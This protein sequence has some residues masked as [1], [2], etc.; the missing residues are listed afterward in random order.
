MRIT[1]FVSICLMF[2]SFTSAQNILNVESPVQKVKDSSTLKKALRDSKLNVHFR[3]NHIETYNKDSL[4]DYYA[5]ALTSTIKFE[6][7][8]Y[9]GFSLGTGGQYTVDIGS[10]DLNTP[11]KS[12]G[13]VSRYEISLFDLEDRTNR[14][15]LYRLDQLFLNYVWKNNKITA[16][17]QL[18]NTPLLNPQDGFTRPTATEA[19]WIDLQPKENLEFQGGF[20]SKVSP[21]GTVKWHSVAESIGMYG[22]GFNLNGT[23]SGYKYNVH[24]NGL[25]VVSGKYTWNTNSSVQLWNYFIDNVSNTTYFQTDQQH[26]YANGSYGI[27]GLILV[28]QNKIGNG[29][30]ADPQKTYFATNNSN[31][32]SGRIG[33]GKGMDRFHLNVTRITGNARYLFPREWGKE[34]FYTSMKRERIEGSGNLNAYTVNYVHDDDEHHWRSELAYGYFHLPDVKNTILNKYMFPSFHQIAADIV[35][36]FS[37]K[38]NNMDLG[39]TYT[40]KI[41]AA[42]FEGNKYIINRVNMHHVNFILNYHL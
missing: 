3:F 12:T 29:G 18:I 19:I 27:L 6:T 37:G 22:V 32:I 36:T 28:H 24:S 16:G 25:F 9:K 14:K 35:Y 8:S 42:P 34:P 7:G 13:A 4:T 39:F 23:R 1:L 15:R 11:D 20:V 26:E 33:M 17:R 31:L 38:L 5:T 2:I 30:N 10:S 21:R 40:Y 41:N